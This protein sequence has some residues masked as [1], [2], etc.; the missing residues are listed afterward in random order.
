M[1]KYLKERK[2]WLKISL[3]ILITFILVV[4]IFFSYGKIINHDN[5]RL[6]YKVG[7]ITDIHAGNEKNRIIN[8]INYGFPREYK[9]LFVKALNEMKAQGVDFVIAAGDNTNNGKNQYADT[10]IRLAKENDME[11][12][13]VKGN[14]D[15]QKTE[16]MKNFGLKDGYYYYMDKGKWRIIVLDSSEINPSSTGGFSSEQ[17]SWLKEKLK[18]DKNVVIAMHHP[19]YNEFDLNVAN[20][21]YVEFQKIIK[22]FGN[23]RYVFAGHY[24]TID[25]EKEVDGIKY[26]IAKALTLEKD[27]PNFKIINL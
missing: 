11:V 5:N 20:D 24:H 7:L 18:T 13:W 6:N 4:I 17:L 8:G 23:V 10:L 27:T 21:T 16:V 1:L 25:S 3:L 22:E 9:K 15:R 2:K 12:I 14:H 26:F 19:V